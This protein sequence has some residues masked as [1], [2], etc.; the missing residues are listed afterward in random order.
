VPL[1]VLTTPRLTLVPYA[2]SDIDALH[3]IWTDPDVRRYLWDDIGIL[4]ERAAEVVLDSIATARSHGIGY[5]TVRTRTGGPIIGDCGF[6]FFDGTDKIELFNSLARAYWG[7]GLAFEASQ[8]V[9]RY[10]WTSTPFDRI[11]ARID[12]PN[13][14][15]LRLVRRLGFEYLS[16][17]DGLETYVIA[18]PSPHA[19]DRDRRPLR[20]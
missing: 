2:E 6:H 14:A 13:E 19:C 3:A 15:S 7:Q 8:A 11:Y 4:R 20:Y 5:W 9:L 1:P 10:A 12:A 17:T 16:T 18:G